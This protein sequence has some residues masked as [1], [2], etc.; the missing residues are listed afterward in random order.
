MQMQMI[1]LTLVAFVV[2]SNSIASAEIISDLT[3]S[4][5]DESQALSIKKEKFWTSVAAPAE[6]TH[7]SE[8]LLLAEEAKTLAL[9][10]LDDKYSYVQEKL[11]EASKRLR[12]ANEALKSQS[13]AAQDVAEQKIKEDESSGWS[14]SFSWE[15]GLSYSNAFSNARAKLVGDGDFSN[16]VAKDVRDRQAEVE[17]VLR[18]AA[19]KLGDVLTNCRLVS[20]LAFDILKYDI[21]N[22]GVP[23]TTPEVKAICDRLI[24]A[25]RIT[26]QEFMGVAM[27]PVHSL[28]DDTQG[29]AERPTAT[30]VR[31][32]MDLKRF[33]SG[34]GSG[35]ELPVETIISL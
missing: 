10:R 33:G 18:T 26:R 29:K 20:S 27:G 22:K 2:F 8:H 14:W 13:T 11:I 7:I 23:K 6:G 17:P 9:W 34:G 24:A 16:K 35:V 4:S 32:Q 30:V 15:H 3:I 5:G 19:D 1:T 31:A 12:A 25:A 21:Y 28:V